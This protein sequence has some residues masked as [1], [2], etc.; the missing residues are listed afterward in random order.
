MRHLILTFQ[1]SQLLLAHTPDESQRW[2][3]KEE[4]LMPCVPLAAQS[5]QHAA[6]CVKA[7]NC[8]CC[9]CVAPAVRG[10]NEQFGRSLMQHYK[11]GL[12]WQAGATSTKSIQQIFA[13]CPS[14][15]SYYLQQNAVMY[16]LSAQKIQYKNSILVG[17]RLTPQSIN[18]AMGEF[19]TVSSV[20]VQYHCDWN[21]L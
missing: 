18:A 9:K 3:T 13:L 11:G 19:I 20:S 2:R 21:V 5:M 17:K 14:A 15:N 10:S 7:S 1:C 6:D 12:S 8:R 4:R 16:A